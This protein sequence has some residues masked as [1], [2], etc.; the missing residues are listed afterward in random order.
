MM[1]AED[2]DPRTVELTMQNRSYW[3][4]VVLLLI[5]G[6]LQPAGKLFG[7]SG[8]EL[9]GRSLFASPLAYVFSKHHSVEPLLYRQRFVVTRADGS[10]SIVDFRNSRTQEYDLQFFTHQRWSSYWAAL[11]WLP[12]FDPAVSHSILRHGL[13]A[14]NRAENYLA[15]SGDIVSVKIE[16]F[17]R[18]RATAER[19]VELECR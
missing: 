18:G 12:L 17:K 1:H 16:F 13:C 3:L 2:R 15:V 8:M 14:S 7:F 11:A 6:L 9:L 4:P 5:I 19:T 10:S